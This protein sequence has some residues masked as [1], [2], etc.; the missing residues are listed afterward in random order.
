MYVLKIYTETEMGA[1]MKAIDNRIDCYRR[2]LIEP[3]SAEDIEFALKS[4]STSTVI[5]TKLSMWDLDRLSEGVEIT[6]DDYTALTGDVGVELADETVVMEAET[7]EEYAHL[8]AL[9][10]L[11]RRLR[12]IGR[13]G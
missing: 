10:Q 3:S 7:V 5:K 6:D 11:Q 2:T 9:L 12:S 13:I 4:H 1:L 8:G